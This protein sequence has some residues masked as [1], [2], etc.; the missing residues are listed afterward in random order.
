M[1]DDQAAG[2]VT[3]GNRTAGK[4][5]TFADMIDRALEKEFTESEDQN[6]ANDAG[7]FNN[8]VAK[9]QVFGEQSVDGQSQSDG[10]VNEEDDSAFKQTSSTL[11]SERRGSYELLHLG[12]AAFSPEDLVPSDNDLIDQI[13]EVLNYFRWMSYCQFAC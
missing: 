11:T 1:L 4:E 8:S 13:L 2:N 9:Q 7:S 5:D 6:E 12:A 10:G 3:G